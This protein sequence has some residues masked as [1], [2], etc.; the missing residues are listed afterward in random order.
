MWGKPGAWAGSESLWWLGAHLE[1]VGSGQVLLCACL[2]H[3]SLDWTPDSVAAVQGQ[4]RAAGVVLGGLFSTVVPK[5]R[6]PPRCPSC[7]SELCPQELG[8]LSLSLWSVPP[9][10]LWPLFLQQSPL[11]KAQT[12]EDLQVLGLQVQEPGGALAGGSVA[13]PLHLA[14]LGPVGHCPRCY[15]V[16]M[17]VPVFSIIQ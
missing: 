8:G 5:D 2:A 6:V 4:A 17:N 7:P 9:T 3:R 11:P 13:L 14:A 1:A 10:A 12:Q 16:G 15:K